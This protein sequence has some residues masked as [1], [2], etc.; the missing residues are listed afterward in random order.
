MTRSKTTITAAIMCLASFILGII[1]N[2]LFKSS[3]FPYLS[4]AV[5]LR[6]YPDLTSYTTENLSRRAE[7]KGDIKISSVLDQK[8]N[9]TS[10]SIE[11]E[12]L[13]SEAGESK[14]VSGLLNIPND[15]KSFPLVI[16]VRGYVDQSIY[17][18]GMGAQRV[19]E[20]FAENGFMT[21]TPDFL[22]YGSSNEQDGNIFKARLETYTT[23]L[24]LLSSTDSLSNW[25]KKN[26]FM[27]GH[28]NGGHIAISALEITGNN[29][30]TSLWAPVTKPFPYSVLYYTDESN[31]GGKFIRSELSKFEEYHDSNLF[32]IHEF[33]NKINAPIQ[34]HQGGNDSAVPQAW[35]DDFVL[36]M[37]KLDKDLNYFVY[38]Q[39]DHNMNPNW[40]E[41]VNKDLEFFSKFMR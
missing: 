39:A 38:P 17:Q 19:G 37:K 4:P 36:K 40:G 14:K 26:L 29:I 10:Y 13:P 16:L 31:D 15:D 35:S 27:W 9:F 33:L 21:I 25:D 22:G 1:F 6:T 24:D 12:V 34:I 5:K 7:N 18:T 8:E 11:F 3:S 23:L 20:F 2:N 28:S 41:A 30:P 32:S